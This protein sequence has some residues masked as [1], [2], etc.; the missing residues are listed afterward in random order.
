VE[1]RWEGE[2]R[3]AAVV[4]E[5]TVVVVA[6]AELCVVLGRAEDSNSAECPRA[7]A[8][9]AVVLRKLDLYKR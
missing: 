9:T 7:E 2:A 8:H 1:G 5:H 4:A 6:E 3:S